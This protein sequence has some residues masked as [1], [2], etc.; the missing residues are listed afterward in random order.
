MKKQ[1]E[2]FF[3]SRKIKLKSR[4]FDKMY[5]QNERDLKLDVSKTTVKN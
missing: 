4:E 3:S 2:L 1:R 5:H